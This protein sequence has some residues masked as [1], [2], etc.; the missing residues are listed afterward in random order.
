[1]PSFYKNIDYLVILSNNEGGLMPVIEAI[2]S[3]KPVIAPDVGWCWDY[4]V[5][6]YNTIEDLKQILTKLSSFSINDGLV[7]ICEQI[8][9]I[10]N[11]L[12]NKT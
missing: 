11:N 1:M 4:P 9:K 5:I 10:C 2:A 3:G 6:K 12:I 8:Q 7:N